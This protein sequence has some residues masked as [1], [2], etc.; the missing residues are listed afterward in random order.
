MSPGAGRLRDQAG[1]C[2]LAL[3]DWR[4]REV[5]IRQL[6]I[7]LRNWYIGLLPPAFE[8]VLNLL[9]F[10]LGLG[11]FVGAMSW[12]HQGISY[13]TYLAPGLIALTAFNAPFFQGLYGAYVRMHYQKTWEGQLVTQVELRHVVA[14]EMVWAGLLGVMFA[15]IV[16]LVLAIFAWSGQLQLHWW[17]LPLTWLPAFVLGCAMSLFGLLFT[18]VMPS[19]DHMNLPTFLVGFPLGMIS[20]TYF[21]VVTHRTWLATLIAVNPVHHAAEGMRDL[22]VNGQ[23]DAHLGWMMLIC[24]VLIVVMLPVVNG[25][26]RRRVLGD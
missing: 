20:D 19:I 22:L 5:V 3:V 25:L 6:R 17:L 7:Y 11:A 13:L 21:P 18:A 15:A 26:M 2:L 23:V 1:P 12:H 16:S 10:G 9:V 14:G 8:P 4:T 24:A